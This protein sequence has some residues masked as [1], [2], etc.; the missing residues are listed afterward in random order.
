MYSDNYV[1]NFNI[2]QIKLFKN[3]SLKMCFISNFSL[4]PECKADASHLQS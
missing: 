1:N 2:K 3:V 4:S